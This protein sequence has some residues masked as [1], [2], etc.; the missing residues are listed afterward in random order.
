MGGESGTRLEW[1]V[2]EP[3]GGMGH[4][5]MRDGVTSVLYTDV[6]KPG[7]ETEHEMRPVCEGCFYT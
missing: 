7:G 1:F 3:C 5:C 2:W 4:T 6:Q